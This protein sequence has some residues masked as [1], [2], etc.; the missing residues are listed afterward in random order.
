MSEATLAPIVHEQLG[1]HP[2]RTHALGAKGTKCA[3]R[4]HALARVMCRA[5]KAAVARTPIKAWARAHHV[6]AVWAAMLGAW[7]GWLATVALGQ[8]W[9]GWVRVQRPV[10]TTEG[11]Q[12][13]E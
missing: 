1:W 2:A 11:K 13:A 3:S 5:L 9:Q 12:K 8:A 7:L 10:R 4:P 6:Q